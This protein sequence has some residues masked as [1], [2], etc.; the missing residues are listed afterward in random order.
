MQIQTKTFSEL[1]SEIRS[2]T[3]DKE[4]LNFLTELEEKIL[5]REKE[6]AKE[7]RMDADEIQILRSLAGSGDSQ[8]K[9]RFLAQEKELFRLKRELEDALAK[10]KSLQRQVE[11]LKREKGHL[12][13]E[14]ENLSLQI[15]K[16]RGERE[17]TAQSMEKERKVLVEEV[18]RLEARIAELSQDLI[19][20]KESMTKK[21][22]E[23]KINFEKKLMEQAAEHISYQKAQSLY[24]ERTLLQGFY[25]HIQNHIGGMLGAC[26]MLSERASAMRIP[27]EVKS[28][29]LGRIFYFPIK[30]WHAV[31]VQRKIQ[32]ELAL[33]EQ[34]L[35]QNQNNLTKLQKGLTDF[36]SF[37][38]WQ[39][40]KPE[41]ISLTEVAEAALASVEAQLKNSRIKVTKNWKEVASVVAD[42]EMVKSALKEILDNAIEAQP[43]IGEI[44]I[45]FEEDKFLGFVSVV[46]SDRGP[47]VPRHLTEK[48]LQPFFTTKENHSGLGLPRTLRWLS[49]NGGIL[50]IRSDKPHGEFVLKFPLS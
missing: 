4:I 50:E 28:S 34:M 32:M 46:V 5:E 9:L 22:E 47:G 23:E 30:F 37:L 26:Q 20:T 17:W 14:N 43:N 24:E 13:D 45:S 29:F 8:V 6:F 16:A 49:L 39:E 35:G 38:K 2:K 40:P 1:I 33:L 21:L 10:T 42:R 27:E 15:A 7:K 3:Q 36:S 31:K 12:E 18:K 41:K 44:S 48:I 25:T 19:L 11:E